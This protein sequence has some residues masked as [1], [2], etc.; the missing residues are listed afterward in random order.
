MFTSQLIFTLKRGSPADIFAYFLH[1][2]LIQFLLSI[3]TRQKKETIEAI[4]GAC[5]TK[6][7]AIFK[8]E[9]ALGCSDFTGRTTQSFFS[10]L[11]KKNPVL[12][13]QS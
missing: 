7:D 4:K 2:P 5:R 3:L 9:K 12:T 1:N 6:N 13:I 8:T 10:Q 11:A